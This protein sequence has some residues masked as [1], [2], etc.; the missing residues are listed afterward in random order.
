MTLLTINFI[1]YNYFFLL[2]NT[3]NFVS[4][5]NNSY[6]TPLFKV[7][8]AFRSHGMLVNLD[9]HIKHFD[10]LLKSA[11]MDKSIPSLS[12]TVN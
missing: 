6:I 9:F 4:N 11:F 12:L 5:L 10:M 7:T 2:L 8:R 1:R 3:F